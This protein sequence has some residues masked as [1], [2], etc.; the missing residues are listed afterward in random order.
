MIRCDVPRNPL[1]NRGTREICV[2]DERCKIGPFELVDDGGPTLTDCVQRF[3]R[4]NALGHYAPRP[5]MVEACNGQYVTLAAY[6]ALALE[7][8]T[9]VRALLAA[10][11]R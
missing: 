8:V 3:E 6:R 11:E 2:Y 10:L 1:D 4:F 5:R 7:A 9:V